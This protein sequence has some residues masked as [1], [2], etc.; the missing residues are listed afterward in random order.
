MVDQGILPGE[1]ACKE[2]NGVGKVVRVSTSFLG[3]IVECRPYAESQCERPDMC[4]ENLRGK[5]K[6]HDHLLYKG[7][8]AGSGMVHR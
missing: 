5:E 3:N 7:N 1:G 8:A 6:P 2:E 4:Q